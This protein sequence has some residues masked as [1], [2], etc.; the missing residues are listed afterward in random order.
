MLSFFQEQEPETFWKIFGF[1]GQAFF[2]SRFVVQWWVSERAGRSIVPKVFWY[3]SL[4]G[5]LILLFY[6]ISI[7]DEVFITG[8]A[9]GFIVYTR[10]LFLIAKV[11]A[12][13]RL[14]AAQSGRE[15]DKD[16]AE[17]RDQES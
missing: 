4:I 7:G 5:S 1:T 13:E 10:N 8:Q 12:A 15:G 6:A 9:L 11:A 16:V 3:L 17:K 2:G 14:L